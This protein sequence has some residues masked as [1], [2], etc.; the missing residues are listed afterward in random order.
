MKNSTAHFDK[1]LLKMYQ[2]AIQESESL[3][4]ENKELKQLIDNL[5]VELYIIKST[6]KKLI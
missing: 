4:K 6:L 3:K 5:E 2:K 1:E